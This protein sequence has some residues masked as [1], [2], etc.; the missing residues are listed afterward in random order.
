MD[1]LVGNSR[2]AFFRESALA[3]TGLVV[4]SHPGLLWAEGEGEEAEV[5]PAEDL[6]REHGVLKRVLPIY[7]E[8]IRRLQ[9]KEDLPPQAVKDSAD[10]IRTFIEDYHE[11]LEEDHLFPR[12]R[13]AN[14]LVELVDIL[15]AQHEAGRKLTDT[16]LRLSTPEALAGPEGRHALAESLRQ[17]I[18]MYSPH[19]AGE[20][21]VLFPAFRGIVSANEYDSLGEEFEDKEHDLFGDDGFE[22][23]VDRVATIEK[24]LGIFDLAQFTP[25]V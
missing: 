6:M 8:A 4:L 12:F 25:K 14:K 11:K 7:E 19:E 5:S 17:F 24:T 23:M 9:G 10:I 22:N 20:G 1:E 2:R 21:T 15:Q 18:R 3:A 16:T 13:K